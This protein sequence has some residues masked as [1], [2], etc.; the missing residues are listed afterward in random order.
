MIQGPVKSESLVVDIS[1]N[2]SFGSFTED[3][4]GRKGDFLSKS[5]GG[6]ILAKN[7]EYTVKELINEQRR[8]LIIRKR[9][10]P[11]RTYSLDH[12]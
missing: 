3:K 10:S 9:K 6:I 4:G 2:G 12:F 8:K 1:K 7:A 5:M 11:P